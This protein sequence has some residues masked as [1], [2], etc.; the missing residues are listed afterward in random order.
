VD[1]GAVVWVAVR[2]VDPNTAD[3]WRV[4]L[5]HARMLGAT[6]TARCVEVAGGMTATAVAVEQGAVTSEYPM[7]K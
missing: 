2:S 1:G 3:T 6:E 7:L 5:S 4:P